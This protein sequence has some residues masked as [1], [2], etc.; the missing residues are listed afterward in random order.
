MISLF[1]IFNPKQR[2]TMKNLYL[3][4][5]LFLLTSF[6]YG[7]SIATIDRANTIDAFDTTPTATT[8]VANIS[9]I[10]ITRGSGILYTSGADYNSRGWD[11]TSLVDAQIA[12]DYLE[13][14]ISADATYEIDLTEFDIRVDRSSTGP[15]N[16]Q[17]FYSLDNFTTSGIDITGLQIAPDPGANFNFNTLNINSGAEGTISF[18]LYAWGASSSAG[19]FDIEGVAA[20]SEP[21][22]LP[23]PGIRLIGSV[24]PSCRPS[25]QASAYNTSSPIGTTTATLNWTLGNGDAV[26]VVVKE[27][28]AV[29]VDP[30]NGTAYILPNTTFGLGDEIETGTGNYVVYSGASASSV[31]ITGLSEATT[32][33]VAIYEY[34]NTG[35]CY[36]VNQLTGSFTT[37]CTTPTNVS[38][39]SAIGGD[40]TIDLNWTNASLF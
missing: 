4:L 34:N 38:A 30:T 23:D 3:L 20:W 5:T 40:T 36:N 39:L 7:Q 32:Y 24:D 14:S 33:H 10:G 9:A 22:G 11:E 2:P 35:Y 12:N 18:R 26:L 8:T 29:D 6:S 25:L 16:W 37:D 1:I 27:G 13:W 19:T 28:A 15:A 31:N 21:I 17:I